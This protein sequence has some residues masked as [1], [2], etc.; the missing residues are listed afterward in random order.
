[1]PIYVGGQ[2]QREVM[3]NGRVMAEAWTWSAADGWV[4]RF[5]RT[6]DPKMVTLIWSAESQ[7]GTSTQIV[8]D[9]AYRIYVTAIGPGGGGGGGDGAAS[10]TGRGGAAGVPWNTWLPSDAWNPGNATCYF[11]PRALGGAKEKPGQDGETLTVTIGGGSTFLRSGGDGGS[12]YGT[13]TGTAPAAISYPNGTGGFAS[14]QGSGGAQSSRGELGGGGGGGY[15]GI[16]GNAGPGYS[17]GLG[18]LRLSVMNRDMVRMFYP[19][20]ENA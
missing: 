20:A 5:K 12:G 16:F 4:Q 1:M 15:G 17:G 7:V 11:P 6:P 18:Y 3:I 13:A 19:D 14:M 10:R 8:P 9:W 2:R